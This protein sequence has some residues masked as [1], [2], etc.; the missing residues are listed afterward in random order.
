MDA[1]KIERNLFDENFISDTVDSITRTRMGNII[2]AFELQ[3]V[4]VIESNHRGNLIEETEK[5]V[6]VMEFS[7]YRGFELYTV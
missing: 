5:S 7:N 1:F 2:N 6:Q 4:R 3:R